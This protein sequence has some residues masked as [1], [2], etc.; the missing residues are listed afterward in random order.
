MHSAGPPQTAL[1]VGIDGQIGAALAAH[2]QGLGWRVFGTTRREPKE[3]TII[4]LDLANVA[5]C[6]LPP[7]VD[8]AFLCAAETKLAHCRAAPEE[9]HTV[10]VDGPVA[11]ATRLVAGGTLV[12]FLSSNA[13]FD[14]TVGYRRAEE[15]TCPQTIYGQQKARAEQR[16]L[17]IGNQV[18]ILRLTKV[19][20]P[21]MP[22]ITGWI[23]CLRRGEPIR[24]FS[25]LMI[26]PLSMA[27]VT[28][29]LA[30]IAGGRYGGIL[31]ASGAKDVSYAEVARHI[32]R[33]LAVSDTLVRPT[34]SAEAGLPP[35]DVPAHTTLDTTRLKDLFD[36]TPPD[37]WAVI[38][39]T[40]VL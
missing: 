11:L 8:A 13:V 40:F 23:D 10:N 20:T 29:A 17:S 33:R 39:E 27:M 30:R 37:P 3:D 16:L 4:H 2:L 25:D 21:A 35:C 31:Q 26:A 18:A 9:T 5:A 15:P 28:D 14:G 32:A 7:S 36:I 22:L 19:L 6:S 38:D 12:V 24:P 34:T 1:I